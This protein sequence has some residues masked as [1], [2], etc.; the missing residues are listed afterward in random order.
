M[1]ADMLA[2]GIGAGLTLVGCDVAGMLGVAPRDTGVAVGLLNTSVQACSALGMGALAAIA[3]IVTR[4][5]IVTGSH[6]V[7]A[8]LTDGYVAG[9]LAGAIIFAAGALVAARTIAAPLTPAGAVG[10][11]RPPPATPEA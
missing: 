10:R 11:W 8:A 6:T 9:L 7:A 3:S 5:S 2:G 1:R 4:S